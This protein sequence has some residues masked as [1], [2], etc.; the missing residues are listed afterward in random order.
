MSPRSLRVVWSALRAGRRK[1]NTLERPTSQ[2]QSAADRM[3][4]AGVG[5]A[6]RSLLSR[7]LPGQG[8]G[9]LPLTKSG[10]ALSK[11]VVR[12]SLEHEQQKRG[13]EGRRA[14]EAAVRCGR[15]PKR[16][17]NCGDEFRDLGARSRYK[18]LV[19]TKDGAELVRG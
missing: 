2:L 17:D 13:R 3:S 16:V 11:I 12:S 15:P 19:L 1:L 9:T 5:R 7:L 14:V 4:K 6:K 18:Q 10:T 8:T